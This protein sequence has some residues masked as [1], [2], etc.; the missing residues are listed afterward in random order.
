MYKHTGILWF[1]NDLRLHDN[2]ALTEAIKKCD[3][4]LPVYV[5]DSRNFELILDDIPKIGS[6]RLQRICEALHDLRTNL[7][8]LGSDLL[9]LHG[10][11]EDILF[12]LAR[13]CKSSGIFCN[14]ERTFEEAYIQ[15]SLE[16]KL[17]T[18]GQEMYFFRGKM[19]IH[20]AD[21][22][23]P[24]THT[25]DIFTH[26]RK[27]IEG[28]V[29]IRN[30]LPTPQ[31]IPQL[32]AH[33]PS[34]YQ[35]GFTGCA[36]N[37]PDNI[38]DPRSVFPFKA[39]EISG[40]QRVKN[41]MQPEGPVSR[42]KETRNGLIGSDYST[43]FSVYLSLG[44]L[45]PK[46]I[47]HQLKQYEINFGA[48]ESTYWV[49]FELLW[50]DFFR[51]HA[52]KYGVKIFQY[53]GTSGRREWTESVGERD[54][55]KRW[56]QGTTGEP[57]IDA[58]MTELN[59]TGF[60]SNRGRQNVASYLVHD[61]KVNWLWGA[62]YFESLLIDFDPC[63]NYGNWAYIAGVGA[64]PRNDRQFNVK[65]QSERYDPDGKYVDLWLKKG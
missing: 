63:S 29:T 18:I 7:K 52:K 32:P 57:F 60:M 51:F 36:I 30:P 5:W 64:D 58:N 65:G 43:K 53:K 48:N 11:T 46:Y 12:D 1:R 59:L 26:F 39:G 22:P 34:D 2:E 19:M 37:E 17:W 13:Q 50:R 15:N 3:Y 10:K 49:Y 6:H 27:E 28:N 33:I 8:N 16:R 41:Y 61:L 47:Y 62:A 31:Y 55:F 23:F 21:L 9:I 25:P 54:R 38:S 14:R 20:T 24:V 4:L 44:S 42:Y 35:H 45:S 56:C 40:L